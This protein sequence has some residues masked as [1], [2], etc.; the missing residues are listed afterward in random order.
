MM[1]TELE[2]VQGIYTE[3]QRLTDEIKIILESCREK[4]QSM[5]KYAFVGFLQ[6]L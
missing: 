1:T 2:H 3:I 5:K 6:K 4:Q